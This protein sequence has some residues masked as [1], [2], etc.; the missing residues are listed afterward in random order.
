MA[1]RSGRIVKVLEEKLEEV[2]EEIEQLK[3]ERQGVENFL[4]LARAKA[5]PRH[6][7]VIIEGGRGR[8]RHADIPQP[9]P[10]Y[11]A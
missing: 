10:S 7:F 9:I 11:I 1:T 5:A 3:R 4:V 8:L 2:N 6:G